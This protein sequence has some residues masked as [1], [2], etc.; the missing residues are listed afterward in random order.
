MRKDQ[1][2]FGSIELVIILVVVGVIGAVGYLVAGRNGKSNETKPTGYTRPAPQQSSQT[3]E[4]SWMQTE[5][6]YKPSG[7]P[8]KCSKQMVNIFP[9]DIS[10]ATAV[11]YPG[12]TRGGNYKP[13]GGL[14]FDGITDNKVTVR[15]PFDGTLI[16]GGRY[17]PEGAVN[18]VQY[19]FDVINSCGMMYRVGHL[20]TLSPE[21]QKIA[22]TFP[23]PA[24]GD[25]RTTNVN[26]GMKI[27]AGTVLATAVG[28]ATDHN[29]FFDWG[30]YDWNQPN[31]ISGD[32]AWLQNQAHNNTLAKHAVCWFGLLASKDEAKIRGLPP[33][34][35]ASGKS[36]DYCK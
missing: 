11:L 10:K 32:A 35:P 26:P 5:D 25:S 21:L 19:T 23:P 31:A 36:S 30:V 7:T 16:D 1:S 18:D 20:L 28:T 34:D 2:G 13:H 17:L 8:P 24:K 9:T 33:G 4:I 22:E 6:G 12:Q 27:K 15:A 14:R 29:T 3:Q